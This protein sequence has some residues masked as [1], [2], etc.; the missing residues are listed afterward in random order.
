MTKLEE[1]REK[2]NKEEITQEEFNKAFTMRIFL[3]E[4]TEGK[5]NDYIVEKA[6]LELEKMDIANEKRKEKGSKVRDE[7]I[8]LLNELFSKGFKSG[9]AKEIGELLNVSTQKGSA[10]AR[11]GVEEELLIKKDGKNK[12]AAKVYEK[13]SC[14]D[15][16]EVEEME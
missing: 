14:E 12:S 13:V 1:I 8:G 4:I 16:N 15:D 7:N 5:I 3:E 9:T 11:L 10:L 6:K 2:L